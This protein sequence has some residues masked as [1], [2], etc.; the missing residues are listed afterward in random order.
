MLSARTGREC[1]EN[2]FASA[3]RADGSRNANPPW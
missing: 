2:G 1:R 3:I